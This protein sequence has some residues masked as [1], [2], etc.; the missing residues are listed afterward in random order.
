MSTF[1]SLKWTRK[2]DHIPPHI[3][4]PFSCKSILRQS[5]YTVNPGDGIKGDIKKQ[6][7]ILQPTRWGTIHQR[8]KVTFHESIQNSSF[9]PLLLVRA[10]TRGFNNPDPPHP[11]HPPPM[12]LLPT[13][14]GAAEQL[15]PRCKHPCL[16]YVAGVPVYSPDLL[17][18]FSRLIVDLACLAFLWWSLDSQWDLSSPYPCSAYLIR[19]LWACALLVRTVLC[20]CYDYAQLPACLPSQ[21]SSILTALWYTDILYEKKLA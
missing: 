18:G 21:S 13:C 2:L 9:T 19:I 6:K 10:T 7:D 15:R 11:G 1:G 12:H 4:M 8:G 14:P 5:K 17:T 3:T 20:L 16:S